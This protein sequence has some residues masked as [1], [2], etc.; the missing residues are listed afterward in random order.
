MG[1]KPLS[2]EE[3]LRRAQAKEE[4]NKKK[5]DVTSEVTSE[6]P[7]KKRG[8]PPLSEEEKAA[9]KAKNS[10][11]DAAE[12]SQKKK[13]GRPTLTDEEKSR[14]EA[15][16]EVEKEKKKAEKG[17]KKAENEDGNE[18]EK[19]K[20]RKRLTAEEKEHTIT[21]FSQGNLK[22]QH[23]VRY[24]QMKGTKKRRMRMKTT[25]LWVKKKKNKNEEEEEEGKDRATVKL[26]LQQLF[27]KEEQRQLFQEK[28]VALTRL[29]ALASRFLD[30]HFTRLLQAGEEP[31]L[32]GDNL[33]EML[34]NS[35]FTSCHQGKVKPPAKLK[36][37]QGATAKA[38][39]LQREQLEKSF[40]AL[41][42]KVPGFF[43]GLKELNIPSQLM[44][45]TSKAYLSNLLNH[46][47]LRVPEV[48]KKGISADLHLMVLQ[49]TSTFDLPGCYLTLVQSVILALAA[50]SDHVNYYYF[51]FISNPNSKKKKKKNR[52]THPTQPIKISGEFPNH[53]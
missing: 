7:Q 14:R 19:G 9:K 43:A 2:E 32:G 23:L 45:E 34:V 50:K 42:E 40:N 25:K 6:V 48:L 30:F 10:E 4:A 52:P 41:L 31:V 27:P 28:A 36:A 39:L 29:A 35:T 1:R 3:K 47:S 21:T 11:V 22:S 24:P 37:D 38:K 20:A 5:N 13:R 44:R 33:T 16:K 15:E 18:D 17:K 46:L 51:L 12:V 53:R 49:C 8:R 26:H